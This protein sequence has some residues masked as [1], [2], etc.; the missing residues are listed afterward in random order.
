MTFVTP[1]EQF[2]IMEQRAIQNIMT[3]IN[4]LSSSRSYNIDEIT[5]KLDGSESHVSKRTTYRYLDSLKTAGFVVNCVNGYYKMAEDAE[6]NKKVAR[7]LSFSSE[8]VEYIN[9]IVDSIEESN[10]FKQVLKRKVRQVLNLSSSILSNVKA[11]TIKMAIKDKK[12]VMLK[13]YRSSTSSPSDRIV[14]PFDIVDN[15]SKIWCL[16]LKDN[17]NKTFKLSRAKKV[18]LLD[19]DWQFEDIHF[20]NPTDAFRMTFNQKLG[21]DD[22]IEFLLDS[23]AY[24]MLADQYQMAIKE[25]SETNDKVFPYVAKLHIYSYEAPVRFVVSMGGHVRV[26]QNQAFLD[27]IRKYVQQNLSMYI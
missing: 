11:E 16:D 3:L 25:V 23:F 19:D 13:G 10:E 17:T 21:V 27:E 20:S 8:E 2:F 9:Y 14:E 12:C 7:L 24:N 22:D 6:P 26:S 18:V 5:E 4:L 1:F 15:D